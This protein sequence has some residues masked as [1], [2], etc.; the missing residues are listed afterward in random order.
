MSSSHKL[1]AFE[2]KSKYIRKEDL[3]EEQLKK[4]KPEG[5]PRV[6]TKVQYQEIGRERVERVTVRGEDDDSEQS[7]SEADDRATVEND[8]NEQ[9]EGELEG[10]GAG[11]AKTD[12][13][14]RRRRHH[15]RNPDGTS[16]RRDKTKSRH[17][18][19][20]TSGRRRKRHGEGPRSQSPG[21]E[22]SD[23]ENQMLR[24]PQERSS[25]VRRS[26][27]K[28]GDFM[29]EPPPSRSHQSMRPES[30]IP[31]IRL[32]VDD[33]V[34]DNQSEYTQSQRP[35]SG[36][37][38]G[39][40]VSGSRLRPE[41]GST[42]VSY[43]GGEAEPFDEAE[44][45]DEAE[46][47][48][49]SHEKHGESRHGGSKH[50]GSKH[51][52]SR[53]DEPKQRKSK[54]PESPYFDNP[55]YPKHP[56]DQST[57]SSHRRAQRS[58]SLRPKSLRPKSGDT[59]NRSGISGNRE[60]RLRQS[61]LRESKNIND[62]DDGSNNHLRPKP[63]H[64][65]SGHPR[66]AAS[67]SYTSS[68]SKRPESGITADIQT[69]G[70]SDISGNHQSRPQSFG[71]TPSTTPSAP[72]SISTNSVSVV[73]EAPVKRGSIAR[74]LRDKAG[75]LIKDYAGDTIDEMVEMVVGTIEGDQDP[76]QSQAITKRSHPRQSRT[77]TERSQQS[78]RHQKERRGHKVSG[79][80]SDLENDHLP[81]PSKSGSSKLTAELNPENLAALQAEIKKHEKSKRK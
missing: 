28:S 66:S 11:E 17:E 62:G 74:R 25:S 81:T 61:G 76:R 65:R 32:P 51:R 56:D 48:D 40:D 13:E 8:G 80:H 42:V 78:S 58:E 54:R 1:K 70:G 16:S 41:S 3:T 59:D 71:Y 36:P 23:N 2:K 24:V 50:G 22:N 47:S 45:S 57:T 21:A 75:K 35:V 44:L 26:A 53:H 73:R 55:E 20:G 64:H 9:S 12:K 68:R 19:T 15:H 49:E 7:G 72:P 46:F 30:Q 39:S 38:V 4:L 52:E 27:V 37:P 10:S 5:K 77:I 33:E 29:S 18:H 79:H 31:E 60:S 6:V 69:E 14:K 34:S 43:K 63:R 67:G